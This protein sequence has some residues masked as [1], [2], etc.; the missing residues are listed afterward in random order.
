MGKQTLHARQE[1]GLHDSDFCKRILIDSDGLAT[2]ASSRWLVAID[3]SY[4]PFF[5]SVF[6]KHGEIYTKFPALNGRPIKEEKRTLVKIL[7]RMSDTGSSGPMAFVLKEYRYPHLTRIGTIRQLPKAERE[8]RSL[9]K[10]QELGIP[11]AQPVGFGTR[12]G[13]CG[14]FPASFVITRLVEDAVDL[15]NWLKEKDKWKIRDRQ[16]KAN[17]MGQL[18]RYLKR[19]HEERFFLMRPS[20]KNILICNDGTLMFIDLAYAR[21]LPSELPARY[22]QRIDLGRLFGPL[23]RRRGEDFVDPFLEA[24]LPDPFGRTPEALRNLIEHIAK[25]QS[26]R[27]PFSWA[28]NKIQRASIRRIRRAIKDGH[29][30]LTDEEFREERRMKARKG[31]FPN[32]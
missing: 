28:S 1:T 14:T 30:L 26:N 23:L 18:G 5:S 3:E 9:R 4:M 10:C 31:R 25:V 19:L 32:G 8:Y 7:S 22:A 29:R 15:R 2:V 11:T 6:S 20:P 12:L 21:S 16:G 27:T 24:Y 17:I 13:R